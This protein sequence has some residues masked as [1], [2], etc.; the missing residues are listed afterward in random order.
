MEL[1]IQMGGHWPPGVAV[2]SRN[3]ERD[4]KTNEVSRLAVI[5]GENAPGTR[6]EN[7]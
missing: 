2:D 5:S 1:T 4:A 6:R 3:T 7:E